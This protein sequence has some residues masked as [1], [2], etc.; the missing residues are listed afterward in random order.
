MRKLQDFRFAEDYGSKVD[1]IVV[2][3]FFKFGQVASSEGV[4]VSFYSVLHCLNSSPLLMLL[5]SLGKVPKGRE[6][7]DMS[8][9]RAEHT[10]I[11][12]TMRAATTRHR[13]TD[14]VSGD[15]YDP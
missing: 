10:G 15:T 13:H 9:D 11:I 1:V 4:M 5:M 2:G 6:S 7:Q 3:I 12:A 14:R 8:L